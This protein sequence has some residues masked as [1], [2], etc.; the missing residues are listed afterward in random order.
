[1]SNFYFLALKN[2]KS[3]TLPLKL[4]AI[5][6]L[7]R[8]KCINWSRFLVSRKRLAR[9]FKL[10]LNCVKNYT[11]TYRYSQTFIPRSKAGV[12]CTL[13]RINLTHGN[14]NS[15]LE[16][17]VKPS[18]SIKTKKHLHVACSVFVVDVIIFLHNVKYFGI[19]HL[20]RHYM[21]VPVTS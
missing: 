1:M 13:L 7:P 11:C 21:F 19:F 8:I 15:V 18:N 14:T 2:Q 4:Q 20:F 17:V 10:F 16:H 5:T 6:G 9:I 3:M 12:L